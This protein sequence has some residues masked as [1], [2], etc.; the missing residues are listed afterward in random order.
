MQLMGKTIANFV[1]TPRLIKRL[2]G[3]ILPGSFNRSPV[4]APEAL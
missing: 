2:L 1:G 4:V 3:K